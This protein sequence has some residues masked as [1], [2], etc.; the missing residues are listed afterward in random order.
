MEYY[1][2]ILRSLKDSKRYIGITTDPDR[3]LYEHNTGLVL[4]TK[5][6]RPFVRIYL[7]K[8]INRQAARK[9]EKYFKS[10]GGRRFLKRFENCARSSIG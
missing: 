6:R 1:V 3:R 5:G 2:Y 8:C 4:S 9:R 7:E 10:G